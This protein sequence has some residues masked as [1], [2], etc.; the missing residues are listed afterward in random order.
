MKPHGYAFALIAGASLLSACGGSS[1][2]GGG[3]GGPVTG[4]AGNTGADQVLSRTAGNAAQAM[5]DGR[6][7]VASQRSSS[8]ILRN[9]EAGTAAQAADSTLRLT[10]N[11]SGALTM[12]VN[13]ETIAFSPDDLTED[14]YGYSRDGADIWAWSAD[15]MAN[16][17]DPANGRASL[18]F[19][20]YAR[21]PDGTERL[22]FAVV[23]T[24]TDAR[25]LPGLPRATYSGFAR[26]RVAPE[27]GFERY[28]D[29][30]SE[31][32]G[33]LGM[34][35]DFG[36]GTISGQVTNMETRA[37]RYVDPSRSWTP[38]EGTLALNPAA[39][40]GNGFTGGVSADSAF[41]AGIG[42]VDPASSYSGTFFGAGADEVAGGISLG[43]TAAESGQ[44]YVGWGVFQGAR[45]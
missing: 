39:M 19:D 17:L 28:G 11:E 10:R 2:G 21:L 36:A 27:T 22:G 32:R 18:V 40:T 23:G 20:H 14:G 24:E 7:L 1:G 6:T 15:S 16:Q 8:G 37:P 45:D 42:S 29:A 30:V 44:S 25:D 3:G 43:G 38:A 13:G 12:V 34:A 33:D 26:V 35:A 5:S 41:T 9:V 4:R 31:A